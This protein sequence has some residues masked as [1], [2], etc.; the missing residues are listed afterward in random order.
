MHG[1]E[2]GWWRGVVMEIRKGVVGGGI[3]IEGEGEGGGDELA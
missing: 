1:G 2:L 3:D